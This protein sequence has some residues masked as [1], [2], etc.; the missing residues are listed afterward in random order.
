MNE[1]IRKISL[2]VVLVAAAIWGY[3]NL[4]GDA[5]KGAQGDAAERLSATAAP[6]QRPVAVPADSVRPSAEIVDALYEQAWGVDPFGWKPPPEAGA[7]GQPAARPEWVLTGIF[8]S[9]RGPIAVVNDK[10]VRVGETIDQAKVV[11]INKRQVT[12]LTGD[13]TRVLTIPNG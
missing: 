5:G 12:L 11:D 13:K 1:R 4:F 6:A 2:V 7:A 8:F 3:Y 9:E 10:L